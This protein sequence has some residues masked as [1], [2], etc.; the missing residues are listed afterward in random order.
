MVLVLAIAGVV[1]GLLMEATSGREED[2]AE[3]EGTGH[4]GGKDPKAWLTLSIEN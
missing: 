3:R 4:G 1:V 2:E